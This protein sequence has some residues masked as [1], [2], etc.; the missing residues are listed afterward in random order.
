M[1][2]Q[3]DICPVGEGTVANWEVEEMGMFDLTTTGL[4]VDGVQIDAEFT[5]CNDCSTDNAELCAG[6]TL[7]VSCTSWYV[8]PN[9]DKM[10]ADCAPNSYGTQCRFCGLDEVANGT[11]MCGATQSGTPSG[12]CVVRARSSPTRGVDR[13]K[14]ATF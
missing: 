13:P 4:V 14:G 8:D 1:P 12:R 2:C 9:T 7:G 6:L 10:V 11:H 3:A 5:Q